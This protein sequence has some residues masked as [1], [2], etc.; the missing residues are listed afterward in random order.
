[1]IDFHT[2]PVLV[3]EMVEGSEEMM[4]AT[5]DIFDCGN[6]L[7]PL[8]VFHLQM[9]AGGVDKAVILPIA[10]KRSRGLDV[11]SNAQIGELVRRH[12]TCAP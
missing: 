2:Y 5:R 9:D 11:F 3:R 8:E 1:M 4:R 7:Q 10:C 12:R 6:N